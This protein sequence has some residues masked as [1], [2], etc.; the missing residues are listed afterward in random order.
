M[1]VYKSDGIWAMS[2]T[3]GDDVYRFERAFEDLR[4]LISDCVCEFDGK[5]FMLSPDDMLVHNGAQ[6]RSVGDRKVR[7]FLF[8]AINGDALVRLQVE[9]VPHRSEIWIFYPEGAEVDRVLVWNWLTES[10]S[11]RT[12]PSIRQACLLRPETG[13]TRDG[14]FQAWAEYP[15]GGSSD[16]NI[17]EF[18]AVTDASGAA[19]SCHWERRG[20]VLGDWPVHTFIRRIQ[21]RMTSRI[22]VTVSVGHQMTPNGAITWD[23]VRTFDSDTDVEISCRSGG[24]YHAVR[25]ESAA[26]AVSGDGPLWSMYGMTI[27]FEEQGDRGE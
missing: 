26:S 20:M 13:A 15:H 16:A 14:E 21:F 8:N 2:K 3:G 24:R 4:L 7:K 11:F 12:V 6:V 25:V 1:Y 19:P 27:E 22:P 23:A 17:Y 5:H 18:D 9:A 10:W